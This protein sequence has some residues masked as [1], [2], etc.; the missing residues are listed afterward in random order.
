MG[1][2][3]RWANLDHLDLDLD[4][5]FIDLTGVLLEGARFKHGMQCAALPPKGGW[6]CQA[7]SN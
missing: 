4:L 6:G 5:E 3:L 1:A 2:D 7:S